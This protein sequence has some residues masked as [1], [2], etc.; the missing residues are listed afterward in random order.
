[1][2]LKDGKNILIAE[3]EV[4]RIRIL[5]DV[6]WE[7]NKPVTLTLKASSPAVNSGQNFNLIATLKSN[8]VPINGN[9]IFSGK[10]IDNNKIVSVENGIAI[11]NNISTTSI[12]THTY[13]ATFKKTDTYL[14]SSKTVDVT[15]KKETPILTVHGETTTYDTWKVGVLLTRSDGKTPLK[16]REILLTI[17]NDRTYSL[18][19]NS[20]G[21]ATHIINTKNTGTGKKT[22]TYRY[23][24]N[25][26]HNKND[27]NIYNSKEI[28]PSYKINPYLSKT[29][30][31]AK[32]SN[33]DPAISYGTSSNAQQWKHISDGF[34]CR[35]LHQTCNS[36]N[37]IASSSGTKKSADTLKIV[38]AKKNIDRIKKA[39]LKF[40]ATSLANACNGSTMGGHF[41]APIVQLSTDGSKF[42]SGDGA[43]KFPTGKE[44]GYTYSKHDSLSQTIVWGEK[45]V[46]SNITISIDY[47]RNMNVEEACLRIKNI[48]LSVSYIPEQTTW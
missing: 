33:G 25:N 13:T 3:K 4:Q 39:T 14:A 10:G 42:S 32:K 43:K 15:V 35:E 11:L 44:S 22:F 28:T 24:A 7:K 27:K 21:I 1:M 12:G 23:I 16:N 9:I 45:D 38:Y 31:I 6:V 47:G 46:S 48:S 41:N 37:T 26:S 2:R 40:S 17:P 36:G 19:T 5:N 20:K 18:T 29:L 8:D 34:Q 30:S